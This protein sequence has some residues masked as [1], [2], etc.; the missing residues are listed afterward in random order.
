VQGLDAVPA[1]DR[2]PVNV[3]RFAFQTMVGI[4]TLLALLALVYLAV[5]IRRRRL[6][7]STWFYRALAL[8]GPLSVVALISGWVTTEVGRQPWVVY[9]VMRTSQAVT[10]ARG[11][12]VGYGTLLLVYVLLIAAVAWILWRLARKPLDLEPSLS[13]AELD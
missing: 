11:I 13:A 1:L 7:R 9:G 10:G 4:G 5:R 6:P 3:V 12:P 8:A 2:P